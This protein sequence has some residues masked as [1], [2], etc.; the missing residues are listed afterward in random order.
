MLMD[1]SEQ[2]TYPKPAIP[3]RDF[4][5]QI[6]SPHH[7]TLSY[8][9]LSS[10]QLMGSTSPFVNRDVPVIHKLR[11]ERYG[12]WRL[13][14]AIS[15][16]GF[17]GAGLAR[18][19]FNEEANLMLGRPESLLI[20]LDLHQFG[21]FGGEGHAHGKLTEIIRVYVGEASLLG[22]FIVSVI[23]THIYE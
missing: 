1:K 19:F 6:D 14:F 20:F 23:I 15:G 11:T 8:L 7:G 10:V 22:N 12:L 9:G 2:G 13:F 21:C 5:H 16:V 4:P 3:S 18:P 17:F